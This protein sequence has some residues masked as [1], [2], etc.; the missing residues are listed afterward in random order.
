MLR[1]AVGAALLAASG[2]L[3]AD[4]VADSVMY[5]KAKR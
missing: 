2:Y 4:N 1:K 3:V 5:W